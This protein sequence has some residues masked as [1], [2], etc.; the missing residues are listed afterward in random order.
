MNNVFVSYNGSWC[1]QGKQMGCW[2]AH[3]RFECERGV[4]FMEDGDGYTQPTGEAAE[5][6]G[7]MERE[8]GMPAAPS[9]TS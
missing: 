8:R 6:A 4:V 2:N 1:S 3:W 7:Q 5:V 9:S